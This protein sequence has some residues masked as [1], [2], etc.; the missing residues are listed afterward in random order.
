MA[1]RQCWARATG[2]CAQVHPAT[3]GPCRLVLSVCPSA[4]LHGTHSRTAGLV[5]TGSACGLRNVS[6]L[7]TVVLERGV[8]G[9]VES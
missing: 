7:Y 2:V 9:V 8:S 5:V 4:G 1:S 6:R 3:W